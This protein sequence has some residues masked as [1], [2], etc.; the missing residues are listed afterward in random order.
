MCRQECP[1]VLGAP[2]RF[3]EIDKG[4]MGSESLL[5]KVNQFIVIT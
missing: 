4:V 2:A 1:G 3:N 5:L